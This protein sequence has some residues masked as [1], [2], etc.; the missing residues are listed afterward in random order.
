MTIESS[1]SKLTVA[2]KYFYRT[3]F[4]SV[5]ILSFSILI[6]LICIIYLKLGVDRPANLITVMLLS[7]GILTY[8]LP[9]THLSLFLPYLAGKNG[10]EQLSIGLI[11]LWVVFIVSSQI[12]NFVV[13]KLLPYYLYG[14]FTLGRHAGSY[15]EMSP[16]IA[17]IIRMV[18]FSSLFF[19][20]AYMVRQ[21]AIYVLCLIYVIASPF[22]LLI[23]PFEVAIV[24]PPA[25]KASMTLEFAPLAQTMGT[26]LAILTMG[27][28]FK[29]L[30]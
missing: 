17:L 13:A 20:T 16:I 9:L 28:Q 6:E 2:A 15:F 12:L 23:K 7:R 26:A 21:K 4:I 24:M 14:S 25:P 18:V 29:K 30:G 27:R 11:R 22:L 3:G 5:F 10:E 19:V 8:T 1:D